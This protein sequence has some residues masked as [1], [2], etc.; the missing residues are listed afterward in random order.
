MCKWAEKG[1]R[2]KKETGHRIVGYFSR[3]TSYLP[4]PPH[5]SPR[6]PP[7]PP[8]S[9]EAYGLVI[10]ATPTTSFGLEAT[11]KQNRL[12]LIISYCR[13][14]LA[15]LFWKWQSPSRPTVPP[16]T[17]TSSMPSIIVVAAAPIADDAV[18]VTLP[19]QS[20]VCLR[21]QRMGTTRPRV[22]VRNVA[23]RVPVHPLPSR[24]CRS[25]ARGKGCCRLGA[26]RG[27]GRGRRSRLP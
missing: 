22:F 4:P 5:R 18:A 2:K 8:L 11:D 27:R 14:T 24:P 15:Y 13:P 23:G 9:A 26:M 7:R 1:T 6:P 3:K 21:A 25:S 10:T 19:L 16:H 12:H 20:L 17:Q